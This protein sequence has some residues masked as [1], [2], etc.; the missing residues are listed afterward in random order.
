MKILLSLSDLNSV[1]RR[2]DAQERRIEAVAR[3]VIT[4][5]K[6][7]TARS[8]IF[9]Q[10]DSRILGL[11]PIQLFTTDVAAPMGCVLHSVMGPV[12]EA[13]SR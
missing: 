1:T 5:H 7:K 3:A 9:P 8:H 12:M 11:N 13:P 2:L 4:I 10:I 6:G